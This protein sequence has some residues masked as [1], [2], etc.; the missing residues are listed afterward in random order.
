MKNLGFIAEYNCDDIG[1]LN[2][3]NIILE[4]E[5]MWLGEV[6]DFIKLE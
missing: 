5:K 6:V 2:K 4:D 3:F 1:L